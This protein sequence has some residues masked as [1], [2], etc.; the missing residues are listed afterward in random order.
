M[1]VLKYDFKTTY[2]RVRIL[3]ISIHI[4]FNKCYR[5]VIKYILSKRMSHKIAKIKNKQKIRV[6][7]LVSEQSKWGYQSVYN[8]FKQD[9]RYEP[10][11]LITKLLSQH[12]GEGGNYKNIYDCY[13]AYKN[14]G[15]NVELAYDEKNHKYIP[16]NKLNIDIVFYQQPWE[17]DNSQHPLNVSK[18]AIT[19]YMAYGFELIED[20]ISYMES[21]H[22]WLDLFFTPS[23]QTSDYLTSIA[24]DVSN[25]Y[26]SG[27]PKIDAYFDVVKKNPQKPVVIYAPHHSFEKDGLNMATFQWNGLDILKLAQS[28]A[29]K[30]DWVFKPHPRFKHA[31]IINN[32]MSQREIEEYYKTWESFGRIYEGGDY[33]N[34]FANSAAM[35]TDCCSFLAEYLPSEH[36]V[37]HLIN[38]SGLFNSVGKSFINSYY[39]IYN[40]YELKNEFNRVVID[41]DDYKKSE[42]L[43]KIPIVFD[44]KQNAGRNIFNKIN[45]TILNK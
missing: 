12:N 38:P 43:S 41:G 8:A 44:K 7:F 9:S 11:V 36:P 3:G 18:Y 40:S 16:L 6:G 14:I 13:K 5:Q 42:R 39:Q 19:G 22:R 28:T 23:Q 35:I 17:L 21:F 34:M 10:V 32:I 37:L 27:Y 15:L 2:I 29:D 1:S 26:I 33:I 31:V 4:P 20:K 30:I 24:K 45:N 25:V